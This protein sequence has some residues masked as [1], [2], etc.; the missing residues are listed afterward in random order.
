LGA[1]RFAVVVAV[2][3]SAL[4]FTSAASAQAPSPVLYAAA[5]GAGGGDVPSQL[6]TVNPATGA[7]TAVGLIGYAVTGLAIDP[8]T[9]ILYGVTA[10][11]GGGGNSLI[12][13]DRAT[14]AGTV[15]GE[16]GHVVAELDFNSAGQ[17]FGWSE[18]EDNLVSIDKSTGVATVVGESGLDT[19]GDGM[20]FDIQDVLYVLP[21]GDDGDY[22]TVNTA[23]G[24]PT[25]VGTLSNGPGA[26]GSAI[27][28]ASFAC[29]RTTFYALDNNFAEDPADLIRVNLT[30]GVITTV[31]N[32]GV[33]GL[34]ALVWDCPTRFELAPGSV[35]VDEAA[36]T[37]TFTVNRLGG[38][39]GAVSVNF[40]TGDGSA[41]AGSDYTA[42][43][44][45]LTFA[46]NETSKTVTI[47]ILN[48]TADEPDETFTVNLS[49]ATA[50]ATTG[51]AAT[52]TITDNDAAAAADTRAPR[53]A[54]AGVPRGCV[55][56]AFAIRVR[57]RDQS[58]LRSVRVRLNGRVIGR[59]TRKQFRV[60]VLAGGLRSGRHTI[61][62]TATDR[63]G[64]RRSRTVRFTR[65]ARP[66]VPT[67]TG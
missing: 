5:G 67:L 19:Y 52:V 32:T 62:I 22:Y 16:L 38:M 35:T 37:V 14:G 51:P 13:I 7:V 42:T 34:S 66:V 54:V 25:M 17:L 58:R 15:V 46:N 27:G 60:R 11:R 48:D 4:A 45:T 30:T 49:G 2:A 44:G 57:I 29:D 18:D 24:E 23:T 43:S 12:T 21:E 26:Q 8:T 53:I 59:T 36:G 65:C 63:A 10:E 31:G 28:A 40:S 9:G 33:L 50:G 47:P 55:R 6:Y 20:S 3:L 1:G 41:T 56:T 64:N 39:K 61:R